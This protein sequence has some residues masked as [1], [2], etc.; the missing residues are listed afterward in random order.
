MIALS[1]DVETCSNVDV[2]RVGSYNYAAHPSTR[3]RL[4]AW[5]RHD[6]DA[7]GVWRPGWKITKELEEGMR[8]GQVHAWNAQF[9]RLIFKHCINPQRLPHPGF[10]QWRCTAAQARQNA[11][12]GKLDKCA[13][14]LKT[15]F[16]K[17]PTQ[18]MKKLANAL[19]E[20]T[21]EE[22][23]E[24]ATYC[25][26]D[27]ETE[28]E[29]FERL[30]PWTD[31]ELN[32]Y[33]VNER[34]N[35]RGVLIDTDFARAMLGKLTLATEDLNKEMFKV[36]GGLVTAVTQLPKLKQFIQH[37][38]SLDSAAIETI[39][40]SG[41]LTGSAKRALELRQLGSKSSTAKYSQILKRVSSDN[42][43]RGT[44]IYAGAGQT[45]RYSSIGAQL[46]NLPRKVPDDAEE[47]IQ[48]VKDISYR[49]YK[50]IYD[51][52][53]FIHQA[54]ELV[55]PTLMAPEGK[56]FAI[57]DYSAV[58]AKGLP[59]LAGEQHEIEAWAEGKDRYI[60]DASNVFNKPRT[61]IT[62]DERQAGK[63]VRL[64]C[65][66]SGKGGALLAMAKGYGLHLTEERA[67]VM[68]RNWHAANPWVEQ[69]A[70]ALMKAAIA[71]VKQPGTVHQVGEHIKY[72]CEV[73]GGVPI[74]RCQLPD[75][76]LISY[77]DAKA[78][79]K[80]QH[81]DWELSAIKPSI[82]ARVRLW[83]GLL[84]ENVT[85]ATC[86][87]LMRFALSNISD[88]VVAHV[89]DEAVIEVSDVDHKAQIRRIKNK[90]ETR[91]GWA[92]SFPLVAK[93]AL[94]KRYTK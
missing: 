28:H 80:S 75:G 39:L 4:M 77:H 93:V 12:P 38:G 25:M 36:T 13:K 2:T 85:Q 65:G 16:Q 52:A 44:F 47:R 51:D 69:F 74:L 58:E 66:F 37:T 71:A 53:P 18:I 43:L 82:A 56:I 55:R 21:S 30:P 42:R 11:L 6:I 41:W 72:A 14:V 64:A 92:L 73:R 5:K 35:D 81:G 61:A 31:Q 1:V 86:A 7:K 20:P 70:K 94:S 26:A 45:K 15:D 88:T 89:H 46:H 54:S 10:N 8:Y 63:V 49:G 3:L 68:A 84:A 67:S 33:R 83:H 34:I 78:V 40:D 57:G 90:M 27:V 9:E 23:L 48:A 76:T 60:E 32:D 62:D 17:L 22:L 79:Y 24:L 50:L 59:W 29:I 87:C 19:Y 91:P